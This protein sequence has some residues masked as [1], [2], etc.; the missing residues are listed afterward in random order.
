MLIKHYFDDH[1]ETITL[2]V[3]KFNKWKKTAEKKKKNIPKFIVH[4]WDVLYRHMRY[5]AGTSVL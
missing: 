3:I 4:K 2:K 1:D 5:E